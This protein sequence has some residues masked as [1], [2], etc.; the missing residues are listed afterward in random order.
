MSVFREAFV[1][2]D[3]FR[4]RYLEAGDGPPLVHLHGAGGLRLNRS[5]EL[6]ARRHRVIAF[7]MPGFG[8]SENTRTQ[9]QAELAATMAAAAAALEIDRFDLM[10]TSFGARTALYLAAQQPTRVTALVLESPAAIR[11][12]E[13]RPPSGTAEQVARLVY[14]HPERMP[15]RAE[16]DATTQQQI[17][18]LVGRLR[19][20]ARDPVLEKLMPGIATPALVLFGTLDRLMPPTLGRHYKELLPNCN[21]V[22][23]YD[24][25]HALGAERPEA[26]CEVVDD[27]LERREAFI[28]SR[29]ET[30]IH[31]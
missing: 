17:A 20:P 1:D 14:G 24:A 25:G 23:V 21:L 7:E 31:P 27:F 8:A 4:L 9:D 18:L 3:G 26:F 11:P 30:L 28:V 6:L 2:A 22:L 10:G 19:G 5:H 29:S 15:P 12:A 13:A 16:V